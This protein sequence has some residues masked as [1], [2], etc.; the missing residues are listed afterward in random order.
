MQDISVI[1]INEL[2]D[3]RVQPL[4]IGALHQQ[5]RAIFHVPLRRVDSSALQQNKSNL[6]SWAAHF[7]FVRG[8]LPAT[9]RAC[10][11]KDLNRTAYAPLV[12]KTKR[13]DNAGLL[14]PHLKWILWLKTFEE[15]RD[16][17]PAFFRVVHCRLT[18]L[19][20]GIR[21]ALSRNFKR[22][23]RAVSALYHHRLPVLAHLLHGTVDRL[24][25][26]LA[27]LVDLHGGLIR[28]FPRV[29]HHYFRADGHTLSGVLRPRC[30][31]IRSPHRRLFRVMYGMFCAVFG[32]YYHCLCRRIDFSDCAMHCTHHVIR[33][34]NAE[35]QRQRDHKKP[36]AI[37]HCSPSLKFATIPDAQKGSATPFHFLAQSFS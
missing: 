15:A 6:S 16:L 31:L 17:L 28:S 12:H 23:F 36:H 18:R 7:S 13:P 22:V 25:P 33:G 2:R 21:G 37:L 10:A 9:S 27:Q 4:A 32:F 30:G 8:S 20:R 26:I 35:R 11:T 19:L 24:Q 3:R 5:N 14:F 34:V 1:T 29:L